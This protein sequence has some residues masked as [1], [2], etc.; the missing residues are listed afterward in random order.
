MTTLTDDQLVAHADR[1]QDKVVIIT[2]MLAQ[3]VI[4]LSRRLIM[5]SCLI[6]VLRRSQRDRQRGEHAVRTIWVRPFRVHTRK[7]ED[8]SHC[9]LLLFAFTR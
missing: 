3:D 2:G 7:A 6:L 8:S 9:Q 1:V 5:R 4:V